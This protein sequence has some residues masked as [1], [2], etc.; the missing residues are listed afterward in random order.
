MNHVIVMEVEHQ[1]DSFMQI[2][3]VDMHMLDMRLVTYRATALIQ[4]V[5]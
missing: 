3:P 2:V 1:Q 5:R 4:L